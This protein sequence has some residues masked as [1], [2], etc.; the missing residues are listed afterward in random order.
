MDSC[1]VVVIGAGLAGLRCAAQLA[2]AGL[3]VTLL[4]AAEVVGGRQR[5]DMVDGFLL[6]RGFQVLNPAYPAV[7]RWVD[8]QALRLQTFPVG[9]RVRR[10]QGLVELAHPIRHP[11]SIPASLRSGLID[12]RQLGALARWVAPTILRPRAAVRAADTTL[13]AGWDRFG[14]AGALRTE[15]L[16]P[17]LAGVIGEDLAREDQ[18]GPETS[19]AF[20]R[21]LIR[22][23]ALGAPGVPA[24]GIAAL[25]AQ[26]AHVARVAGVEIRLGHSV[27]GIASGPRA[28]DVAIRG[29]DSLTARSVV[30]AVG[31]ESVSSLVEIPAPPTRG[32]QT[33]WFATDAA[34][35]PSAMLHVDG[36][37]R[38]PIVNAVVMS[39]AAPTYAP[40]GR[41]LVSATCLL[42]HGGAAPVPE[43]VVRTQLAEMWG[44]G[45]SDLELLRRDDIPDALSAQAAPLRTITPARITEAV[46]V[47][48]DH[49]DTASIQG[50]LVS[51][52]RVARSVLAD[53]TRLG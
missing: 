13:R 16:E 9:V 27:T 17:F 52:D 26:L 51:G 45:A 4:E 40:P 14:V 1:D 37:R 20:A 34:P 3:G 31:P 11:R 19:D 41:H 50:A 29:A 48:G 8:V 23:F 25:P 21:L 53:L 35:T 46:Y 2:M 47:A 38:G 24:A 7:G 12:P 22:M 5:T 39:H 32:L 44:T 33:W 30:L 18:D 36:R 28:V 49:R 6:D 15:V 42:P 43:A 10:A